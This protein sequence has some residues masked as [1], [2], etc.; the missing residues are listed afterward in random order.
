MG[1]KRHPVDDGGHQAWIG[2][3][4]APLAEGEV[5]GH[6]HRGFL[7][8]LGQDLEEQFGATRVELDIAEFIE[9]QQVETA[10]AVDE[11]R[12]PSFVGGFD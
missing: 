3:D 12:Q 11:A 9:Q 1:P 10:V 6:G 7:L 5:R 4:L 8:A 2:D